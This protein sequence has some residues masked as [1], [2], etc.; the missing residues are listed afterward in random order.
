MTSGSGTA[1]KKRILFSNEGGVAGRGHTPQ[2]DGVPFVMNR[3]QI[4]H[5]KK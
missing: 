5:L 3:S 1:G 4:F 2:T